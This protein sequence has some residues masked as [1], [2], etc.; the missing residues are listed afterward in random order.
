MLHLHL[1]PFYIQRWFHKAQLEVQMSAADCYTPDGCTT[2]VKAVV[3]SRFVHCF[4]YASATV[5]GLNLSLVGVFLCLLF[6]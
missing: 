2:I 1:A 4:D 6:T 5:D 3:I